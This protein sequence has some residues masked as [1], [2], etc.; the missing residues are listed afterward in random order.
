VKIALAIVCSVF[1]ILGQATAL[2]VSAASTSVVRHDCGCGG[3]MSCCQHASMP[4]P[5]AATTPT[6]SQNQIISFVPA[7]MVWVVAST[8]VAQISPT[9]SSSLITHTAPIFARNCVRLI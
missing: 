5:L 6:S 4:Q 2:S 3:K 1:L 8:G 7:L 9:V